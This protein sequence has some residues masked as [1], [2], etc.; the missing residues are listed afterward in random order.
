VQQAVQQQGK[1]RGRQGH[2]TLEELPLKQRQEVEQHRK[3][4]LERLRLWAENMKRGI[5]TLKPFGDMEDID[6]IVTNSSRRPSPS[7][8]TEME[9]PTSVPTLDPTSSPRS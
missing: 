8:P 2:W 5:V 7:S 3:L 6:H 9:A 1:Q 4:G